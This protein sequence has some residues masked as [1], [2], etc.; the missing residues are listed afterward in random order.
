MIKYNKSELCLIWLDSFLGLEYKHKQQ[1]YKLI[2]GKTDIKTLIVNGKEYV[3]KCV[4]EKEYLTLCNGAN[5][6]YLDYVLSGLDR[7]G[8]K[9][10]TIESTEYPEF[11]KNT[12]CPP[13]VL[14]VMG[15]VSLLSAKNFSIVGSRKSL[16]SALTVTKRY[17]EALI[18]AGFTL[19]TGIAEGVDATVLQTAVDKGVLSRNTV[20]KYK[21]VGCIS[22]IAGGFDNIYPK[23]NVSLFEKV[24]EGGLV[25]SEYPPEV[26]PRPYLFPVRNR[27]IAAL[28]DG[29][30]VTSGGL[31]SGT[32]Y[33]AEYAEEYGKQVFAIPYGVGVPAGAGCNELIKRGATLTDDQ[34]DILEFYGLES[35]KLNEEE[36]DKDEIE[37][38]E[39]LKEGEQH[40]EALCLK[41]SKQVF[42]LTPALSTLEIKGVIVK[43][44][45]VYGLIRNDLEA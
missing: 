7:R 22:V 5:Q 6:Q 10:V 34:K 9:A 28:S 14:Y 12:P 13:L 21:G 39:A 36:F 25:I 38:I 1:L 40:V 30:L 8:I 45:N 44:G 24:K 20:R 37:I 3:E 33:T 17:A 2:N 32:L 35:Y 16:P 41:L 29:L 31:K 42:E 4:G 15:D 26:T 11:L 23:S 19:V 43:S 27:I 18:D